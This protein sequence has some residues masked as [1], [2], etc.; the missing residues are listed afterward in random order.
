[1]IRQ[2]IHMA[3]DHAVGAPRRREGAQGRVL[4]G[5]EE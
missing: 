3:Q 2:T 4:E 1:M 5:K